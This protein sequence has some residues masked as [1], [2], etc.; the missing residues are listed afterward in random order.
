M[1]IDWGEQGREKK[2][3][4]K[5]NREYNDDSIN[6]TTANNNRKQKCANKFFTK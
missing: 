1:Y 5:F 3:S 2:Y 4:I 6:T